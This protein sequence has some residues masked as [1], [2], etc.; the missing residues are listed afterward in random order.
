MSKSAPLRTTMDLVS[1]KEKSKSPRIKTIR[2]APSVLFR[3]A[4]GL[5]LSD[6]TDRADYWKAWRGMIAAVGEGTVN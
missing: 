6:S 5:R 3:C 1:S 4:Y 2:G